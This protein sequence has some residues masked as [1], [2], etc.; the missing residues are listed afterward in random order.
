M[1]LVHTLI[2]ESSLASLLAMAELY[3]CAEYCLSFSLASSAHLS[4]R[5]GLQKSRLSERLECAGTHL[6]LPPC[7]RYRSRYFSSFRTELIQG[8]FVWC[9]KLITR[10]LFP[11][12]DDCRSCLCMKGICLSFGPWRPPRI[13]VRFRTLQDF[14]LGISGFHLTEALTQHESSQLYKA[15]SLSKFYSM[16][17]MDAVLILCWNFIAYRKSWKM[18]CLNT[19]SRCFGFEGYHLLDFIACGW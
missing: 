15:T 11:L 19:Q 4:V 16:T 14:W 9:L 7:L 1:L 12:D 10:D 13:L 3:F 18:F 6:R 2:V 17:L 8:C 5:R